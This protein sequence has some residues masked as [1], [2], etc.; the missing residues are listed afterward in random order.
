MTH[1]ATAPDTLH[2]T[3]LDTIQDVRITEVPRSGQSVTGYG[4]K[5]PTRYMLRCQNV[6]RRVYVMNYGNAGS[7]Y[8]LIAGVTHFLDSE[9]EEL[10]ELYVEVFERGH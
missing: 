6:W 4:P 3:H 8:I 9:T 1:T 7:A 2:H 10:I 5:I